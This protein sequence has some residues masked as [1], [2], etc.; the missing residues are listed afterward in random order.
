MTVLAINLVGTKEIIVYV[1]VVVLILI[2]LF[3]MTV[4][5]RRRV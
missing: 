1:I 3:W 5:N 2:A 4:R